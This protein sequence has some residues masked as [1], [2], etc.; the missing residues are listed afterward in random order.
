MFVVLHA[1]HAVND[2][3]DIHA[4]HFPAKG[5]FNSSAN[6]PSCKFYRKVTICDLSL[7]CFMF[8]ENPNNLL[9]CNFHSV[10]PLILIP[11]EVMA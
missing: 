3:S 10:F 9:R 1:R 5:F 7:F 8:F 11:W 2:L 4:R 6:A